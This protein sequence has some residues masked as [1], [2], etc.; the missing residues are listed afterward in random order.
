MNGLVKKVDLGRLQSHDVVVI[1]CHFQQQG[2]EVGGYWTLKA[3]LLC[4]PPEA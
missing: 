2:H 1:I 4:I 3:V